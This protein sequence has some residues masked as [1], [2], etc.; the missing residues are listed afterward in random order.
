MAP[1]ASN[2][3]EVRDIEDGRLFSNISFLPTFCLRERSNSNPSLIQG[4]V[5]HS[6]TS[7]P[8]SAWHRRSLRFLR[9]DPK[10]DLHPI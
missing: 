6:E 5:T 7:F 1:V 2:C 3:L 8:G 4:Q 10:A 9:K